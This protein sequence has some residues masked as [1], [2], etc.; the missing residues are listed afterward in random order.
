MC[1]VFNEPK[2]DIMKAVFIALAAAATLAACD[3]S[4]NQ[5]F[6]EKQAA[7]LKEQAELDA[8]CK[9]PGKDMEEKCKINKDMKTP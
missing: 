1:G 9:Q 4:M 2:G 6:K 7:S 3:I 8:Y 5:D